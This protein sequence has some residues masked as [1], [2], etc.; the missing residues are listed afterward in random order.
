MA[1]I[2]KA[3]EDFG[4]DEFITINEPALVRAVH[5][6]WDVVAYRGRLHVFMK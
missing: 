4:L 1:A 2:T 6:T 3:A 5:A